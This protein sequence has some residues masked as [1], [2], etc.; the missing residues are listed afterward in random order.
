MAALCK[1]TVKH[2]RA[3]ALHVLKTCSF[4]T[5]WH[6]S[7][8]YCCLNTDYII[9]AVTAVI[10]DNRRDSSV[11]ALLA[12]VTAGTLDTKQA[13]KAMGLE[14]VLAANPNLNGQGIKIGKAAATM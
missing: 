9:E 7:S 2:A 10:V 11:R 1:D 8:S 4:C 13:V 12:A 14:A 5:A 6:I 3:P